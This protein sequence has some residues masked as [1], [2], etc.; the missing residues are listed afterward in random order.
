MKTMKAQSLRRWSGVAVCVALGVW[1]VPMLVHA[2]SSA[3]TTGDTPEVFTVTG[4]VVDLWCY[5]DHKGHGEKHKVCAI[6]CAK[7]GNPIGIAD[8]SGNIYIAMGGKKHQPGRDLLIDH[9]AETVTVSGKL[10]K[11]GGLQAVYITTIK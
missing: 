1:L 6:T 11:V 10:I 4:E 2:S 3:T 7:A 9:M 8:K 5:M